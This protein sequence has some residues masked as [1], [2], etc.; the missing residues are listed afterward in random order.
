MPWA[1]THLLVTALLSPK[2]KAPK[3]CWCSL[4]CKPVSG[5]LLGICWIQPCLCLPNCRVISVCCLCC[6]SCSLFNSCYWFQILNGQHVLDGQELQPTPQ[7]VCR[8][9]VLLKGICFLRCT[10]LAKW[11]PRL[12]RDLGAEVSPMLLSFSFLVPLQEW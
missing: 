12:G 10:R 4:L 9:A 2:P 11:A 3:G 1:S 7:L 6:C 5:V 8:A